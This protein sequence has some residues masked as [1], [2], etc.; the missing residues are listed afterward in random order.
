MFMGAETAARWIR[1][2]VPGAEF[3]QRPRFSSL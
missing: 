3:V 1:T 2:L